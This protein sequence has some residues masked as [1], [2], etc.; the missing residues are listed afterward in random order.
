MIFIQIYSQL[1]ISASDDNKFGL[2][3]FLVFMYLS[4]LGISSPKIPTIKWMQIAF[5]SI[6]ILGYLIFTIYQNYIGAFLAIPFFQ[7]PV[8]GIEKSSIHLRRFPYLLKGD[9]LRSF[10]WLQKMEVHSNLD[11][12]NKSVGPFLFTILNNSLYQM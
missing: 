10:L 11:I 8:S 5:W 3:H 1:G 2:N 6:S 9:L 12:V 7:P 4:F